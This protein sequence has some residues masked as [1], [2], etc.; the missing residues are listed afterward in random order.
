MHEINSF[1]VYWL[2]KC[3]TISIRLTFNNVI[4]FFTFGI[5]KLVT[6]LFLQVC[7]G[8]EYCQLSQETT[9]NQRTLLKS[10][11]LISKKNRSLN[12]ELSPIDQVNPT[13]ERI[14]CQENGA[15]I[16]QLKPE[17]IF[18]YRIQ[19]YLSGTAFS[20]GT[21]ELTLAIFAR[22]INCLQLSCIN[23]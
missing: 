19:G 10:N 18:C 23:V 11:Q 4:N 8:I 5:L 15:L 22:I 9:S 1:K 21:N 6:K 20:R 12:Q 2:L 17:K 14:K 3:N 16:C 13:L 7:D